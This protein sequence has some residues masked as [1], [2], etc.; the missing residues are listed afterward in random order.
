MPWIGNTFR[1]K[2]GT[3]TGATLWQEADAAGVDIVAV[4]H[5]T[6]DE[7]IAEGLTQALKKD[8]GNTAAA[9]IPMGGNRFTN[10]GDAEAR[11]QALTLGQGQNNKH[12]Y[13]AN[14]G[15][16]ANAI[17]LTSEAG[18]AITAYVAGQV[19]YFKADASNTASVTV[20]IDGVGTKT[21][22]RFDGATDLMTDDIRAGSVVQIKYDGTNFQLDGASQSGA[23]SDILARVLPTGAT[24]FW[25]LDTIP[26]GWLKAEGQAVTKASYPELD[27][28]YQADGYPYGASSATLGVG[29]M[30]LPPAAGRFIRVVDGGAA[31][32]PDAASRTD[33]GDGA[34]GDNVGTLQGD[35]F[36]SHQH[37]ISDPGHDHDVNLAGNQGDGSGNTFLRPVAGGN[38]FSTDSATTGIT[39]DAAGGNE[40]RPKNIYQYLIV[41]ANPTAAAASSVGLFG[42]PYNFDSVTTDADPGSGN[43]R[44]SHAD[45]TS[46]TSIFLDNLEANAADVSAFIDTWDDSGSNI[47][48]TVK[49]SKVGAPSNYAIYSVTGSVTDGTGYRKIAVTHVGS[50]GSFST[51]DP[52]SVEFWR[53]GDIGNNGDVGL[54]YAFDSSTTTTADPGAGD[55]RLSHA[56]LSSVMEIAISDNTAASGNPDVSP[57]LL[58]WDDSDST[59]RGTVLIQKASAKENQVIYNITGASTDE[60]GWVRLAVTHVGS[61]GSFSDTD[62][63]NVSFVRTGDQGA[64][65]AAGADGSNG[66]NGSDAGVRW[67]FDSSTT[68]ADPGSGDIRLNHGTFSSVMAAAISDNS[69]EVGNPD[70]SAWLLSWDDIS[71]AATHGTLTIK[72]TTAPQNFAIFHVTGVTDNSGWVQAALSHVASSGSFSNTDQLSIRFSPAGAD[73]AGS[74]SEAFKTIACP[75]GT[76]PVAELATDTLNLTAGTGLAI[77]GTEGTDTVAF[78]LTGELSSIGGLTS[79]ADKLPYYT[80][81]DAAALA[82]FTAA[83]RAL[84]DDADASAQRTTLGLG[85]LST[86]SSFN[87]ANWSGTDLSVANGGTGASDAS[88]ARTNLGLAIGS[89]VQAYD[90][91]TL[92]GDVENQGP[93]TGGAT[94]TSKDLGTV[95]TGTTTLDYGDRP[96]QRY[97]NGGAHTLAPDTDEGSC[98]LQITNNGSAGAIT[99]SGW[100][101]VTGDAFTETDGHDFMCFCTTT[102]SFSVLNVV[103]LQ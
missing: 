28:V 57:Y 65:G 39:V 19:F 29:T 70:T 1:R 27:A 93:L 5:D 82:D 34:T 42:L 60:S 4:D 53:T 15:G 99:T 43:L 64:T 100:T 68:M 41:L 18:L 16:T 74:V 78:T 54:P 25:G 31:V 6:H 7:D 2:D 94:V 63:I 33:R 38:S 3:R 56:D 50:N 58:T 91:D 37:N 61:N 45:L 52:I 66:T 46:V 102:N 35:E 73:G 84:L 30:N 88:T 13:I 79:A 49:I 83:G 98:I 89:D 90:A 14:I 51:A 12:Q 97:I 77:T 26:A 10:L 22:K 92:K 72:K 95:T 21:I 44:L 23:S 71:N 67:N 36:K 87:N 59:I 47:K 76:N 103:A 8:G 32:D 85:S 20:N 69:G 48:G 40:T 24:I 55:V 62:N 9:N 81:S 75:A 11:T 80:G 17:T 96:N 101:Q 86:L